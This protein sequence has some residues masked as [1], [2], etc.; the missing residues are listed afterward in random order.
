MQ[1]F[2]FLFESHKQ[3]PTDVN[4]D[5]DNDVDDGPYHDDDGLDWLGSLN[6]RQ[7]PTFYHNASQPASKAKATQ[8]FRWPFVTVA[9]C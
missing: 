8:R 5:E 2:T 3:I 6:G 9:D 1:Q 4:D 7:T